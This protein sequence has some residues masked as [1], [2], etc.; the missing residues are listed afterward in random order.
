MRQSPPRQ[1][2]GPRRLDSARLR[3]Q[4]KAARPREQGRAGRAV[5]RVGLHSA[6]PSH[7]FLGPFPAIRR[8][9]HLAEAQTFINHHPSSVDVQGFWRV[10]TG[11]K[12]P[13]EGRR[14]GASAR[15]IHDNPFR[16][17]LG[18]A[19]TVLPLH[20]RCCLVREHLVRKCRGPARSERTRTTFVRAVVVADGTMD[21]AQEAPIDLQHDLAVASLFRVATSIDIAGATKP[22]RG[23]ATSTSYRRSGTATLLTVTRAEQ[24]E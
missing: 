19:L 13:N 15:V 17:G 6:G 5:L 22:T 7:P 10:A 2:K 4:E 24:R 9:A 3:G 20:E 14:L 18:P 23:T 8:V 21:H 11:A 16:S 12:R 1:N